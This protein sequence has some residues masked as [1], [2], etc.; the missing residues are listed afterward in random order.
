RRDGR[1]RQLLV[2]VLAR[3]WAA[4]SR[5]L[6]PARRAALAQPWQ[7]A[8]RAP[9][10]R[11]LDHLR[12]VRLRQGAR[13]SAGAVSFGGLPV[14]ARRTGAGVAARVRAQLA[15]AALLAGRGAAAAARELRARPEL[16]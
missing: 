16:R 8:R 13:A 5:R 14:G 15:R 2:G 3:P 4:R 11:S 10:P 1:D 12:S 9:D 7:P 6:E